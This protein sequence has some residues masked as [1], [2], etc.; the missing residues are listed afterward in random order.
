MPE[1]LLN[2]KEVASH[3][4]VSEEEVK[5]L[6]DTGVIPA[7]KI[8]GTFLRFRKEQLD[9]IMSEI[10]SAEASNPD[11]GKVPLNSAG[12]PSHAYSDLEQDNKRKK[13][14]AMQFDYTVTER[15]KDF[16]Y[17]NDFYLISLAVVLTLIYFIFKR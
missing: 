12:K 4:K 14:V 7:Y 6:V 2:I 16:F 11:H 8:G 1:K 15:I 3:L 17:F 10:S 9:A 13:P 5:R